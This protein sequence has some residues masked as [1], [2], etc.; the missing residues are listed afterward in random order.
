MSRLAIIISSQSLSPAQQQPEEENKS[1][2][3]DYINE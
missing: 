2:D 3:D 1:G